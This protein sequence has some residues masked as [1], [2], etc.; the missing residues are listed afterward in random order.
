MNR[1]LFRAGEN[2]PPHSVKQ[3]YRY[4]GGK[5]KLLT[6]YHPFFAGLHP[7]HCVDY[8]G[9]SG[10]MSLWFHQLYPDVGCLNR[11]SAVDR[12]LDFSCQSRF[13]HVR[14]PNIFNHTRVLLR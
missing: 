14:W 10:T 1:R 3:L 11:P 9:G 12:F 6:L 7:Q 13:S 4:A 2:P 8:F 5:G